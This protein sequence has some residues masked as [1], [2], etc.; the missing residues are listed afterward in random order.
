MPEPKYFVNEDKPALLIVEGKEDEMFFK[1]LIKHLK[2]ANIQVSAVGGKDKMPNRIGAIALEP[3]FLNN[4]LSLGIVR[5]ADASAASTFQSVCS[6]LKKANLAVPKKVL[7][8]SSAIVS[9]GNPCVIVMTIPIGKSSGILEDVC[10]E[11]VKEEPTT[12]CVNTYFD[13][14][15]TKHDKHV[16]PKAKLQVYLAAREPELRLG[17]AAEKHFWNW[18]HPVFEP[19]KDFLRQLSSLPN[20]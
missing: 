11:S 19:I 4:V 7:Q 13:C 14:L 1:A 20:A 16:M 17:E 10:L 9:E 6:L 2:L 15:S 12:D 8:P 3:N 18:D 5:D